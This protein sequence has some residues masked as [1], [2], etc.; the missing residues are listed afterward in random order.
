MKKFFL[1]VSACFLWGI[2]N[3]TLEIKLSK[4][5]PLALMLVTYA[6]ALPLGLATLVF[7]WQMNKAPEFP[8]GEYLAWAVGSA[9]L[10]FIADYLFISAYSLGGDSTTITILTLT[11][12]IFVVGIKYVWRG[13]LPSAHHAAAFGAAFLA[14][15]F[16]YRG[17]VEAKP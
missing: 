5:N 7:L 16:L 1:V 10:F 14:L 12:P 11:V 6:T 8:T 13:E 2:Q 4:Y 9:V 15:Y 17:H 3:A